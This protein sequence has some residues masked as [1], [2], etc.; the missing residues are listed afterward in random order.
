VPGQNTR[1]P[2]TSSLGAAC[3]PPPLLRSRNPVIL[4]ADVGAASVRDGVKV[5][6]HLPLMEFR[7]EG[8]SAAR[9]LDAVDAARDCGLAAISA[10]DHFVF[11][12]PWLDGPTALAAVIERSGRMRLATSVSLAALRGPVPL[13]KTLAALDIL[14]GGRL[15]AGV[16]PG[17]SQRDFD[18]LGIPFE[19]R[20]LRF[21]DSVTVLR[22]LLRGE[23]P[24]SSAFFSP[25]GAVLAPRPQGNGVPI[26]I[27][28]WGSEAG[29]ERVARLAD[30]WL[31][32]AYNTTPQRFAAARD[33]LAR[34]LSEAGRQPAGF[35]NGLVTMWTWITE[36]RAEARHAL[37]DVLAPLLRRNPDELRG[38]VCIGSAVECA[39]LLSSYARAGC[40]W[41]QLWPLGEERRQ[42]ETFAERVRPEIQ[43][44]HSPSGDAAP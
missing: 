4:G 26:W 32:S 28:S 12:T 22:A 21:E 38:H 11:S 3:A 16:G 27:G 33:S 35:P 39:E 19:E 5:G 10:N 13:A 1:S 14:S 40:Q 31:A 15:V 23:A 6:I 36:D 41:V 7:D 8:Q 20:W 17:S 24:P 18:A 9:V 29:L 34:K 30:G 42:I 25:P 44:S 2:L 37:K 43:G